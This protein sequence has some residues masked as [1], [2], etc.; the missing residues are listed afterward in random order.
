MGQPRLI[1]AERKKV[2]QLDAK[3]K[4]RVLKFIIEKYKELQKN[5]VFYFL[6]RSSLQGL[7]S[8][9]RNAE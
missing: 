6:F 3:T 5:R 4:D 2:S 8:Y 7:R 9:R 1:M